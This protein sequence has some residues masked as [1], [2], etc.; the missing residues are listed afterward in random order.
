MLVSVST[1]LSINFKLIAGVQDPIVHIWIMDCVFNSS[2]KQKAHWLSFS[3]ALCNKSNLF[4]Y[5]NWL[6]TPCVDIF[7]PTGM[8]TLNHSSISAMLNPYKNMDGDR[9]IFIRIFCV[10]SSLILRQAF[11]EEVL[12]M[13][14]TARKGSQDLTAGN[15]FLSGLGDPTN[16]DEA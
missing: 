11:M 16:T 2:A 10:C 14:Q 6:T 7:S 1:D 12:K 4:S 5:P 15:Y 13:F 8:G 9:K 3:R